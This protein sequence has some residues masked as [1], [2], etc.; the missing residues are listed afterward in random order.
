MKPVWVKIP[1]GDAWG[2]YKPPGPKKWVWAK[3]MA[4]AS[5]RKAYKRLVR[6]PYVGKMR[7]WEYI[8]VPGYNLES[9]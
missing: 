6:D 8:H 1:V 3:V 5:Y 2:L 9:G 7:A 4:C